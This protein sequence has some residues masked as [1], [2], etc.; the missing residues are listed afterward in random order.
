MSQPADR[1]APPISA[2]MREHAKQNPHSWL[3]I[4]DPGYAEGGEDVPPEGIVG[5]YRIGADGEIDEDFQ[6]N[7]R[8]RPSELTANQQEPTN[9]LERVL[10]RIAAGQLPESELPGAVLDAEVLLYTPSAEDT[11]IYTA[12]MSDGS[13]LVPACTST[14]RVPADWPGFRRV[15]GQVLPELL[16]G[17]DLGLNLHDAIQ[18]VIPNSVLV[19]AAAQRD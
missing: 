18:A 13:R 7:D 5:A 2:E 15:P 17:L 14:S 1:P 12:E 19:Q 10:A 6:F 16:D 11:M 4:A 9:E 3:Y 8:Y